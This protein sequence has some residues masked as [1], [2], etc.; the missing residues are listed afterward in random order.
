MNATEQCAIDALARDVARVESLRAVKNVQRSYA[1]HGQFGRWSAMAALFADDATVRWGDETVTGREAI[2][3]WLAARAGAMNGRTPGSLHTEII[4]EPLANLSVDGRTAQV[5]WMAMRFLGDGRGTARIEGG[6]YE[7]DYVLEDGHWRIAHLR[8]HPRF[9]GDDRD[10]W[11]N[12]DGQELPVVPK[13]FTNDETGMPIPPP[14][15]DPPRSATTVEDLAATIGR[16]NDEDAVRNL[17]NAYGYYVDRRMW[18]DVVDLFVE[19]AVVTITGV[20]EYVGRA[21][22]RRAVETMGP[23]GLSHGHLNDRPSFDVIVDVLPGGREARSSGIELGLLGDATAREGYW[24]F[25]AFHNRF[26]KEDGLW[27]LK[28]MTLTPLLRADYFEGWANGGIAL[29]GRASPGAAPAG[30]APLD[31]PPPDRPDPT[32]L[33]LADLTRR[34]ARSQAYDGV[35][36]VSS[37]YGY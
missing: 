35:E 10:G 36:N 21:G 13:H 30:D 27:K 31:E 7:N 15:G 22:V 16:L 17:Q 28:G 37:A 12:V 8:Y 11:T 26:V 5:R 32:P 4:D 34:L 14:V 20:G 9:E 33:D 18:S 29:P 1:Q 23:E 24:E 19:D 2:G 6:I 25:S 3:A